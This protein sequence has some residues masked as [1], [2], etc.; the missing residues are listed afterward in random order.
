MRGYDDR[1]Q[2]R[3][4]DRRRVQKFDRR[5]SR[6]HSSIGHLDSTQKSEAKFKLPQHRSPGGCETI[7]NH[8]IPQNYSLPKSIAPKE[9]LPGVRSIVRSPIQQIFQAE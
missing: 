5:Q 1:P 7:D 8:S 2:D 3:E 9:V 4:P 6:S